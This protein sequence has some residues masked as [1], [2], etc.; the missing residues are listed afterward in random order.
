VAFLSFK[1]N[2]SNFHV[3]RDS[4]KKY[5]KLR[6]SLIIF[7]WYFGIIDSSTLCALKWSTAEAGARGMG[8]GAHF[9]I[10]PFGRTPVG[11]PSERLI[12]RQQL[13]KVDFN[14]NILIVSTA[15]LF[16]LHFLQ[17]YTFKELQ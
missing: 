6:V 15:K 10:S 12:W 16:W 13:F 11:R 2:N 3:P 7:I 9:F 17:L 5:P 14:T 4:C 1:L 8:D